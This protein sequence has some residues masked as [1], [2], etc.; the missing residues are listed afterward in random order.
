MIGG[1]LCGAVRYRVTGES[2]VITHCHCRMCQRS[3]GA[4][5]VTWA[6]YLP[7]QIEWTQGELKIFASSQNADRGF[8]ANCGTPIAFFTFKNGR[9]LLEIDLTLCSFDRPDDRM[10]QFHIWTS[11]Q[12]SWIHLNDSLPCHAEEVGDRTE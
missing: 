4:A 6:T 1:C 7:E 5:F 12:R 11:S 3:S 10:P 9:E 8:C 2:K